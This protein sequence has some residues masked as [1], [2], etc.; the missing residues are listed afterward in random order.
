MEHKIEF[1]ISNALNFLKILFLILFFHVI[2]HDVYC[3][4]I[5]VSIFGLSSNA[6]KET[7]NSI[8][9]TRKIANEKW[10]HLVESGHIG[11]SIDSI[12][13]IN[14]NTH[15]IYLHKGKKY[16]IDNISTTIPESFK[17]EMGLKEKLYKKKPFTPKN[18]Y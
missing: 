3:Q 12:K 16:K 2:T 17:S 11:A 14:S 10:I 18:P 4:K 15:Y 13:T 8:I 5:N 7:S 1:Y 9:K 6:I